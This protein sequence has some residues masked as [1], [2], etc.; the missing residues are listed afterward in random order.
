MSPWI[1]KENSKTTEKMLANI[2]SGNQKYFIKMFQNPNRNMMNPECVPKNPLRISK[3]FSGV[4]EEES[5]NIVFK[6]SA[7]LESL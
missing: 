7:I 6:L 5:S 2:I 4:S 1:P 3:S